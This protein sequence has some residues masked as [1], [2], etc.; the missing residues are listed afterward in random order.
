MY[1]SPTSSPWI[2]RYPHVLFSRARRSTRS[3]IDQMVRGRPGTFG[4]GDD[5]VPVGDQ[6]AVPAKYGLWADQQPDAAQHV[7]GVSVQQ[8]GE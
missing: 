7:A 6:V 3:R 1:T 2:L 4:T 5:R 8:R